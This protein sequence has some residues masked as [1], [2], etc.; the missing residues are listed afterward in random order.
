MFGYVLVIM[1]K[2]S[3]KWNYFNITDVLKEKKVILIRV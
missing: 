1:V 2:N 3:L